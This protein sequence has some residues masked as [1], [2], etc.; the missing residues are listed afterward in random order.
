MI[1]PILHWNLQQ[2]NKQG[3]THYT[4][5]P[6]YAT[7]YNYPVLMTRKKKLYFWGKNAMLSMHFSVKVTLKERN[8]Y[9][10]SCNTVYVEIIIEN[11]N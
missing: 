2:Y 5:R 3:N 7:K 11:V 4:V 6:N 10:T 8:N 9:F 1:R